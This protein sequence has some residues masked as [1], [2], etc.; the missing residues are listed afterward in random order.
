MV[1]LVALLDEHPEL[2]DIAQDARGH[3]GRRTAL[4]FGNH[5]YDVVKLLLDRGAD[6]NIRDEGD[7]AYPLHFV[8]ER[9]ELPTVELLVEHGADPIGDGDMHELGV[10][11][12]ATCFNPD[13]FGVTPEQRIERRRAVVE[14]L[15]AH[16][17][18]HN[19]LSAVAMDAVGRC[20]S[21][22][23]RSAGAARAVMDGRQSSAT[24]ATPRRRRAAS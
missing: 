10:I 8:A 19:I 17:G 15:L 20:S 12:W 1:R 7:N 16:G 18:R 23:R 5:H 3:S 6:P 11:G 22:C 14:Y 4:H 13:H 21:D 9:L 2:I 24:P